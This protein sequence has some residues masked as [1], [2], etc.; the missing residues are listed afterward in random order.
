MPSA[1][2]QHPLTHAQPAPELSCH[3]QSAPPS[4]VAQHGR[5]WN[6]PLISWGQCPSSVTSRFLVL[7]GQH[8]KVKSHWWSVSHAQQ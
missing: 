4:F 6:I 8:E 1:V 3:P 5:V 2:A 7:A